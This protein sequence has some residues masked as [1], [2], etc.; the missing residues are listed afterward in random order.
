M[1]KTYPIPEKQPLPTKG[2]FLDLT[3]EKFGRLVILYYGGSRNGKAQWV[4]HCECGNDKIV[5]AAGLR[6]GAI[7]SCGCAQKEM[8][9]ARNRS[10]GKSKSNALYKIWLSMRGRC[11]NPRNKNYAR[12]GGR[13]I[14]VCDRWDDFEQFLADMGDRPSPQHSID[15]IDNNKGYSPE[16]CR[17]ATQEVQGNNK[18]NNKRLTVNG[19][20]KTVMQW[21][22]DTGIHHDVIY[23]RLRSGATHEEA[24]YGP[25]FARKTQEQIARLTEGENG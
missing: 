15:R 8:M 16:N 11:K 10:H 14:T 7:T 13:G 1:I 24:I 21:S 23:G 4:A 2:R 18:S 6:R 22:R 9:G 12:Y 20:T 25:D 3:G 17:W 19:K 5:A